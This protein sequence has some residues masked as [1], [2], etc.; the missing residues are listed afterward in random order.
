MREYK[1]V[2]KTYTAREISKCVCDKCG[3]VCEIIDFGT[4]IE[5]KRTLIEISPQYVGDDSNISLDLCP[6]CTRELLNWFPKNEKI[7]DLIFDLNCYERTIDY[8]RK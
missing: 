6:K 2:T 1:K 5:E 7:D 8:E 3:E 4:H